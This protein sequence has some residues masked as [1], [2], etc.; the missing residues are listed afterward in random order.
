[1]FTSKSYRGVAFLA[2]L[3][4]VIASAL[5]PLIPFFTKR[6]VDSVSGVPGFG[7]ENVWAWAVICVATGFIEAMCWRMSGFAGMR[8]ATGVRA[9][10]RE[11]LTQ[12]VTQHSYTFF[13]NRFAGAIGSKIKSAADGVNS[14]VNSILWEWLGFFIWIVVGLGLAFLANKNVGIIFT[15]WM[16]IMIPLNYFFMRRKIP[17]GIAAQKLETKLQ[18]QTIDLL[19]NINAMRDYSRRSFELGRIEEL[20]EIRRRAGVRN[21]QYGEWVLVLNTGL[22]AIFTGGMLFATI[23]AWTAHL[24]TAGD[25]ILILSLIFSIRGDLMH[26][27]GRFNEFSENAS[28]IKEGLAEVLEDH[29]I[30]D[31]A[32]ALDLDV[33]KG[34]IVF[35]NVSF[36]YETNEI[37]SDLKLA[38]KPG[39]R[40]GLVGR[41]GAGKTTLMKLLTRQYD[42][43]GGQIL[44]DGQDVSKVKQE[45]LRDAIGVVPQEP[46]LFH[47]SLKDNIRYGKLEAKNEEI[48]EAAKLAQAHNFIDALPQK[49]STLVGEKGVKLSGGERQRV[50]IAR[51]FLKNAKI[52]LL[53]EATSSLDSE[54]ELMIQRAL[55]KLMEGK[56]VIAIAH[57]LSTLRSM[58]R[59]VV[60]DAGQVVED[61]SHEELIHRGGIYAELWSHQAGG[62]LKEE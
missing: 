23:Y 57:R 54:S 38:I 8:W 7:P 2:L 52:L 33:S 26:L 55:E 42:L 49:Y 35:E 4:V 13:S 60:L 59:I 24:I 20:N 12:Y 25:I 17:L 51:A 1:M 22:E 37:F 39:E 28:Q 44:I 18:A 27:G 34:E 61:G 11:E 30:K 50:A 31:A 56:T 43:N 19:S 29:E 15:V 45:S 46:L 40:V 48:I 62:F 36:K 53:D 5:N 16:A 10:A 41:S 9:R 21:W 47:R 3:A 58:D 6:I 32:R 14:L